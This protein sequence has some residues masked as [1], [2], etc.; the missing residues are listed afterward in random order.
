ML[1]VGF[2]GLGVISHDHIRGYLENPDAQI[3]AVCCPD[4]QEAREWLLKWGLTRTAQYATVEDMLA[5]ERLDIVEI[6]TPTFLHAR[7]AIACARAKVK[8]ISVQKPMALN[9]KDCDDIIDECK[10]SGSILRVFE[11]YLFYPVYIKAKQL[12]DEGTLGELST[13]RLHTAGGLREGA[14]WPWC[15][16]NTSWRLDPSVG[17]I[18]PL[19]GD[20]GHHKFSLARWFMG[21]EFEKV[22]SWIESSNPLD[23]P[24]FIRMKYKGRPGDCPKYAQIDVSFSLQLSIPWDFWLDDFVEIIGSKGI[25]WINQCQGSADRD[26]FKGNLMSKSAAFPPIAVFVDGRV[27]TYTMSAEERSWARSFVN[28]TKHFIDVVRLG[29]TPSY[30]GADGKEVLRCIIASLISAQEQ[31]DVFLDEITTDAEISRA[32]QVRTIF[33]NRG[34]VEMA[35]ECA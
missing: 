31:R 14:A 4:E 5:K 13:I 21:R 25:M 10:Q 34:A 19:T 27:D 8:G 2:A 1:R 22:N 15:W 29:G 12:I 7:H 33:C 26:F 20:D 32:F 11:N 18:G 17:R 28:S 35:P 3:V 24:A 6:L 30:T 9:L 16:Q 23:A